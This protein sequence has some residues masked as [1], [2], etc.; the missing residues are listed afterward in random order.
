MKELGWHYDANARD[1]VDVRVGVGAHH[2][3]R[4]S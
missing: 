2:L 1:H 4:L 3:A